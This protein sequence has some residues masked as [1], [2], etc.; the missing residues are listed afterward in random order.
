MNKE[1]EVFVVDFKKKEKLSEGNEINDFY[2]P[3]DP[4]PRTLPIS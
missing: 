2:V 3:K 4:S 1:E